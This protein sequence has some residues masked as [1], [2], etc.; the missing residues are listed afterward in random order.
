M[1]RT[2]E[3]L[4]PCALAAQGRMT[5]QPLD[6]ALGKI[7]SLSEKTEQPNLATVEVMNPTASGRGLCSLRLTSVSP[8]GYPTGRVQG[9][10]SMDAAA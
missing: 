9:L 6:D 7:H 4:R 1:I 8:L 2:K 3:R 10:L 5:Q